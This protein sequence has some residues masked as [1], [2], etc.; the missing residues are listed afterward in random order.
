MDMALD[1]GV[2]T[3]K[4]A[5][6]AASKLP[7]IPSILLVFAI[8]SFPIPDHRNTVPPDLVDAGQ[9]SATLAQ[10]QSRPHFAGCHD[11]KVK[12]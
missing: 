5:S 7:S 6:I 9:P 11:G 1:A 10:L 4:I 3:T 8:G 12:G 2:S